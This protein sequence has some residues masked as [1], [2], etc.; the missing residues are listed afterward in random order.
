MG[1]SWYELLFVL[2]VVLSGAFVKMLVD[3][4]RYHRFTNFR[5]WFAK[6]RPRS[7]RKHLHATKKGK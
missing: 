3:D 7:R 2:L 1:L 5:E 4:I 6:F